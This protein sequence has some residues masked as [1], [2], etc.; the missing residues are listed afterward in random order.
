MDE[1]LLDKT[2]SEEIITND[3]TKN[4]KNINYSMIFLV[5]LASSYS[6]LFITMAM[7]INDMTNNLN[8]IV[9]VMNV[10]EDKQINTT[11]VEY[12]KNNLDLIQD[13]VLH[14]YCKRVPI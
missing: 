9:S 12:I 1:Q 10:I 4:I 5:I 11:T 2:K 3:N 6:V 14:K 13:C 7:N 8:K